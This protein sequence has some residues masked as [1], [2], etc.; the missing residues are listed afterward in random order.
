MPES[1]RLF[2]LS[3]ERQARSIP[4]AIGGLSGGATGIQSI[5]PVEYSAQINAPNVEAEK[6][7]TVMATE[8]ELRAAEL[9]AAEARTD[10]KIARLEGKIDTLAATVI[11]R[12]DALS[13]EV[14]RG[15]S[16]TRDSRLILFAAIIGAAI[17]LG[18]VIVGMATYGD[19]LF[20]RGMNVR[21]VVQ[22]VVKEQQ[23]AQER[24]PQAPTPKTDNR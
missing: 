22:A 3:E 9:A 14:D 11:A 8:G 12:F 1:A 4:A 15:R 18:A 19:A 17:A 6:G 24:A 13:H 10:T 16:E 7:E 5:P 21:D 20:G 2:S 23:Q